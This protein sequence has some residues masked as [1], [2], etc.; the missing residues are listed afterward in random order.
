MPSKEPLYYL[1][2]KLSGR[3]KTDDMLVNSN[4][5]MGRQIYLTVRKQKKT[6]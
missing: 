2:K 3:K 5:K 6:N 1:L 4:N